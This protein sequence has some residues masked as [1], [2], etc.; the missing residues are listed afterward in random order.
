[1]SD[2]KLKTYYITIDFVPD[3]YRG[4]VV[5]AYSDE[6]AVE[7]FTSEHGQEILKELRYR[8]EEIG[9]MMK[10]GERDERE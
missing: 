8:A 10:N 7:R 4:R 1:M 9:G 3:S 5:R 2:R 6:E